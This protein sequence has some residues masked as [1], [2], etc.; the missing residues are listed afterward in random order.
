MEVFVVLS[1]DKSKAEAARAH[2]EWEEEMGG[3]RPSVYIKTTT[4]M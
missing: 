4:L 1:T 2:Q 3:G